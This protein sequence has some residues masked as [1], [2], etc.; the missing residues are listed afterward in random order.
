M[1]W[2]KYII[3]EKEPIC[4]TST[5]SGGGG[6]VVGMSQSSVGGTTHLKERLSKTSIAGQRWRRG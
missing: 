3:L 5:S 1:S 6:V 4:L 2:K